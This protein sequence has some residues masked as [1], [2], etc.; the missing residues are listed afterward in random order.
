MTASRMAAWRGTG[1]RVRAPAKINLG[2]FVG[3]TR[4]DGRHELVSVMQSVSLADD[5]TLERAK[6]DADLAGATADLVVCPQAPSLERDNLAGRALAAF[7]AATGWDPG[8]LRLTLH[9]DVP[10]AAGMGGGSGDAAAVLRLAAAASGVEDGALLRRLAEG[11]GADVPAQLRPGRWLARGSGERLQEL[12][13]P[14]Q[15]FGV[16]ILPLTVELSTPAVYGEADR[17][18]IARGQDELEE[19]A[20]ELHAGLA[21][22]GQLPEERLLANDLQPAAVA[23][24]PQIEPALEE[25]RSAGADVALVSGSGPTVLGLFSGDDGP[26]RAR[27]AAEALS[28]RHPR[29]SAAVPVDA[30]FADARPVRN[31]GG[32][33]P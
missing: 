26:G 4:S 31:N 10:I 24:C 18:C 13:A 22:G 8:P 27:E 15:A 7:R 20:A 28:E 30:S 25:M 11:L 33:T 6:G 9:K 32:R 23:L 29:A 2:L 21:A 12:P 5:L 17:L 14:R 3:P 16:A 1:W 19:L